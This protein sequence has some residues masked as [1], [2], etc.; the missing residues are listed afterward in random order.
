MFGAFW[1][2][3]DEGSKVKL[4]WVVTNEKDDGTG[5]HPL[6]TL[7]SLLPLVLWAWEE[8]EKKWHTSLGGKDET[9]QDMVIFIPSIILEMLFFCCL[10]GNIAKRHVKGHLCVCVF[11]LEC[12][13]C[14]TQKTPLV[15]G[16]LFKKGERSFS[17]MLFDP[18]FLPVFVIFPFRIFSVCFSSERS[19]H[20][21]L[22]RKM[23]ASNSKKLPYQPKKHPQ[24]WLSWI[25]IQP[26][27]KYPSDAAAIPI[28]PPC[29]YVC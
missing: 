13:S 27:S 26:R 16:G 25:A 28:A 2:G 3:I 21:K 17:H 18:F 6:L 20:V 19:V 29:S 4:G 7:I 1:S 10:Y 8:R 24:K 15:R 14:T 11:L 22:R 9:M 5:L 12:H 23:Q